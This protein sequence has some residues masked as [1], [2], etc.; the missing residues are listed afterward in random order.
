MGEIGTIQETTSFGNALFTYRLQRNA[1]ESMTASFENGTITVYMPDEMVE[2]LV[3]TDR[4][5][6]D[7]RQDIGNGETLFILAEKD[8]QCLDH[9]IEDQTDMY[10]NPNKTC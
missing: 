6:F 7:T 8:F 1:Q 10:L 9:A 5:G 4:I 2:T 3:K